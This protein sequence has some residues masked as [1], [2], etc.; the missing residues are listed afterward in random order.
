MRLGRGSTR[1]LPDRRAF[2]GQVIGSTAIPARR[3]VGGADLVGCVDHQIGVRRIDPQLDG[4][5]AFGVRD[6]GDSVP[7]IATDEPAVR[8]VE[9]GSPDPARGGEVVLGVHRERGRWPV[10]V[11]D[12][13]IVGGGHGQVQPVDQAPPKRQVGM[14]SGAERCPLVAGVHRV[15]TDGQT[16]LIEG[17]A[18]LEVDLPLIAG[19]RPNGASQRDRGLLPGNRRPVQPPDQTVDGGPRSH[20][21][22]RSL[23]LAPAVPV[24]SLG[25][26]VR[27]RSQHLS[28]PISGTLIFPE[29]IEQVVSV[30]PVAP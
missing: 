13:Q 15:E 28:A 4:S 24:T 12:V 14:E 21:V 7:V 19:L 16:A 5:T 26:P 3:L 27:P 18:H 22:Q 9:P 11:R 2:G 25:N 20:L 6:F 1:S 8:R 29:T 10:R 30:D 17:I 23:T